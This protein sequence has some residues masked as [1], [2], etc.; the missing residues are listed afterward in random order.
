MPGKSGLA[1]GRQEP[2]E[3]LPDRDVVQRVLA[4]HRAGGDLVGESRHRAGIGQGGDAVSDQAACR[5]NLHVG[6]PAAGR[7]AHASVVERVLG[8]EGRGSHA[9][10]FESG[11]GRLAGWRGR[12]RRGGECR[13]ERGCPGAGDGRDEVSA[14]RRVDL[15]GHGEWR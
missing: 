12:T 11:V 5:L 7:L 15:V 10:N 8:F 3:L 6:A 2:V 9:H 14:A 4:D 13:S 1:P